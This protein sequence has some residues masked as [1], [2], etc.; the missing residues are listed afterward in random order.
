M[1]LESIKGYGLSEKY[2]QRETFACMV[3]N[4]YKLRIF[5]PKLIEMVNEVAKDKIVIVRIALAISIREILK[6]DEANRSIF[7]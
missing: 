7:S 2:I 4:L 6:D 5:A 1:A 3:R